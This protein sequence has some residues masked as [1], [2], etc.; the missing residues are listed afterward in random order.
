M[1]LGQCL[2]TNNALDFALCYISF[3]TTHSSYISN[4]ALA[5]VL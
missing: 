5:T 1:V 4:I 2:E 3:S